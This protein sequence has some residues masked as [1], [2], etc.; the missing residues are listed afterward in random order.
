MIEKKVF[1]CIHMTR[2]TKVL[3]IALN[4][5]IF[6]FYVFINKVAAEHGNVLRD[7]HFFPICWSVFI[8]LKLNA[9]WTVPTGWTVMKEGRMNVKKY[10]FQCCLGVSEPASFASVSCVC[11]SVCVWGRGEC[12]CVCVCVRELGLEETGGLRVVGVKC[13]KLQITDPK[14]TYKASWCLDHNLY[15]Q[16]GGCGASETAG[17]LKLFNPPGNHISAGVQQCCP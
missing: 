3:R 10:L 4:D 5:L 16:R 11:V 13:W 15:G 8:K 9:G 17:F 12:V 14:A 1:V 7:R 2:H 6:Y